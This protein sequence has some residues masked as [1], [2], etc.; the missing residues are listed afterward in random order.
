MPLQENNTSP[1]ASSNANATP[2]GG[3]EET[4]K[5]GEKDKGSLHYFFRVHWQYSTA[6]DHSL[7]LV[8]FAAAIGSGALPPLMTLIF[9]SS[10]NYFNDFEEGRRSGDD[11][12]K[13]MTAN[14]L[15]LLYLFIGRMVLVYV[16][17]ICFGIVG[18]RVTSAFRIDF[19]RSLLRQDISYIDSCSSGTVSSTIA[20]NADM[21]ENSS[22]EKVGSLVQNLSMY[23]LSPLPGNGSSLL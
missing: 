9:G 23:L 20:N 10:V 15:W 12:Y 19:V 13:K 8:G 3:D 17:S 5:D 21:V 4:T 22:T 1:T 18:I 7:R 16:H 14:A 6:L 11:L 2:K